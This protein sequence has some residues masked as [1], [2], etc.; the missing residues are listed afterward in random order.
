MIIPVLCLN[1]RWNHGTTL[2]AT[3]QILAPNLMNFSIIH[4]TFDVSTRHGN[5]EGWQGSLS[6]KVLCVIYAKRLGLWSRGTYEIVSTSV[7]VYCRAVRKVFESATK[8]E[9]VVFN[10][11]PKVIRF[12][13]RLARILVLMFNTCR[14]RC[15]LF[16]FCCFC[17][18]LFIST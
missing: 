4:V 2:L 15:K 13:V 7:Y 14:A 5:I 3:L 9:S 10:L 8:V 12:T 11:S 6:R 1:H 16:C 17:T 18:A